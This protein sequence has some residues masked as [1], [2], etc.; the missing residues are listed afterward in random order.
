MTITRK[1][2][3][4]AAI[5]AGLL[6]TATC[7]NL[8]AGA[9]GGPRSNLGERVLANTTD[10]Y[11]IT[12]YAGELAQ[13]FVRGD[14]DTDLDLY[15]YD[16]DGN[17]ITSDTDLTDVCLTQWVPAWT[18]TFRIELVNLGSVYNQYDIVTN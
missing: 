6:L 10:V 13:V 17:L 16:E 14:G 3:L 15:V 2:I 8:Q 11:H 18:G 12:F 9:S 4:A 1:N 5:T 7:A